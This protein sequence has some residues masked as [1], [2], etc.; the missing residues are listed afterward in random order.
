MLKFVIV[1][2]I[3]KTTLGKKLSKKSKRKRTTGDEDDVVS[4]DEYK[5]DD[6]LW[7]WKKKSIFFDLPYWKVCFSFNI[8]L[9]VFK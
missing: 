2:G 6:D 4:A 3:L 5:E 1:L 9:L 8:L 7:R